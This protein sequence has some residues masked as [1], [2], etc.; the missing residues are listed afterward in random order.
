MAL[1]DRRFSATQY[2][3]FSALDSAGRVFIGPLAG[4]VAA[5]YGWQT[6]FFLSLACA[7]PGLLILT[8]LRP[9]FEQFDRFR[10]AAATPN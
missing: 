8:T 9:Q 10:G 7:V 6:Y 4:F 2:A 3:V 1:C 5:D